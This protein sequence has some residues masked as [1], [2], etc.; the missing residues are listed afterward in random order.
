MGGNTWN[1][2]TPKTCAQLAAAPTTSLTTNPIWK[3]R[4]SPSGHGCWNRRCDVDVIDGSPYCGPDQHLLHRVGDEVAVGVVDDA[5]DQPA[6]PRDGE[7]LLRV[8]VPP[9]EADRA[10]E[11]QRVIEAEAGVRR[12]RLMVGMRAERHVEQQV[13]AG[14]RQER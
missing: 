9:V 10:V 2:P 1:G 8:Q 13:V 12:R 11:P 4:C 5:A 3:C 14:V 6:V 7:R